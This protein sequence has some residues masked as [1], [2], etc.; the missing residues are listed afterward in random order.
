MAD[1]NPRRSEPAAVA[2]SSPSR[3]AQRTNPR[4][5]DAIPKESKDAFA[6]YAKMMNGKGA[7][8]TKEEWA[9]D[10]WSQFQE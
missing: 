6:R 9:S 7:P 8:L 2:A 3:G 1:D 10:Y 5:F 4:S